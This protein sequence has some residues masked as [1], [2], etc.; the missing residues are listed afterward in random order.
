MDTA[1]FKSPEELYDEIKKLYDYIT[2]T[3]GKN[4]SQWEDQIE[5]EEFRSSAKN[6]LFYLALRQKDIRQIQNELIP[7]GLSSLGR[8]ESKTLATLESVLAALEMITGF[9]RQFSFPPREEFFEGREILEKNA[10][11]ILGERPDDYRTRIMVT[12]PSEC[13]KDYDLVLS[14]ARKGMDIARINC[15]HDDE[16][17]WRKIADNVRRA[18]EE[19]GKEIKVSVDISGPKIRV[20]WLFSSEKNPKISEG[21]KIRLAHKTSECEAGDGTKVTIGTG[22][23]T[24]FDSLEEGHRVLIDDGAIETRVSSVDERGAVLTAEK[25]NGTS[26]RIKPEKGLNFPDTQFEIEVLSEKDRKDLAFAVKTAD[27]INFSFIRSGKDMETIRE[28][29]KKLLDE[30]SSEVKI[31]AKIETPEAVENLAEIILSAAG[32]NPF[33]VMIARG[34]LAVEVGYIRLS[35]LQQEISW[36]CEA[37]GIPVVWATEVLASLVDNGIPARAEVT[38]VAEGSLTECIMLNKGKYIEDAVELLADILSKV[39]KH[40]YKKTPQLRALS[41]ARI[42]NDI[43]EKIK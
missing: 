32:H 10:E 5:R 9:E 21:D 43:E 22:I 38:D 16:E 3:G 15:S 36:I 1:E 6:L 42:N 7:L 34:D 11:E 41:I 37:A 14:L 8:L 2:E 20:E 30:R 33:A 12:M 40:Q 19:T 17:I 23:E 35:E 29:L 39:E 27:I 24:I 25:V 31:M 4:Y 13:S 26:V 28:E 18:S